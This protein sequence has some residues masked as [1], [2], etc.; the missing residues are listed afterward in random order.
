MVGGH[1]GNG[2]VA[3]LWRQANHSQSMSILSDFA[4]NMSR[5]AF[6]IIGAQPLTIGGGEAMAGVGALIE[7]SR[8]YS[9]VG[10]E[11]EV[12][13]NVVVR[14][15]DF[16]AVCPLPADQYL[17]KPATFRGRGFRVSAIRRGET[18]VDVSLGSKA[19]SF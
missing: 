4:A 3:L 6:G 10:Y 19:R 16:D 2:V 11:P 1:L 13:A 18:F 5:Q 17:G 14:R 15:A 9:E 7:D 8:E 12:R